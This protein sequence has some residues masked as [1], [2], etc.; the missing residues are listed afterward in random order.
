MDAAAF[1][2]ELCSHWFAPPPAPCGPA[3][4]D[5]SPQTRDMRPRGRILRTRRKAHGAFWSRK[6]EFPPA[7]DATIARSRLPRKAY[8]PA[9]SAPPAGTPHLLSFPPTVT[10]ARPIPAPSL[11]GP[12]PH[13]TTTV[14]TGPELTGNS[15]FARSTACEHAC[16][17]S[18]PLRSRSP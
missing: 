3:S 16:R 8:P 17:P 7:H 11:L 13:K 10:S 2:R 6:V 15:P 9:R 5:S 14:P 1:A 12:S 18:P 4:K